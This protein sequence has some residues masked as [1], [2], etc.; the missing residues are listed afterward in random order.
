MIE[1]KAISS[2]AVRSAAILTDSYVAGTE[3]SMAEHNLLAIDVEFTIGSLTDMRLKVEVSNDDGTTYVQQVE[4]S[5]SSGVTT[6]TANEYK[7]AASGSVTL[8]IHPIRAG[9]V[10]ISVK[11]TG[12]A[13]GSSCEVNAHTAWA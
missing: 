8:L 1:S 5:A 12:T 7:I 11:G 10:K 6:V 3:F 2:H 4:E 9:L 13:T